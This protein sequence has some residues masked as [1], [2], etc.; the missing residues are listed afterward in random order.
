MGS[1]GLTAFTV[2]CLGDFGGQHEALG[3]TCCFVVGPK[4]VMLQVGEKNLLLID[5][6][7][8]L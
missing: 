4:I 8:F 6:S 5:E 7:T 1:E 3:N 2:R